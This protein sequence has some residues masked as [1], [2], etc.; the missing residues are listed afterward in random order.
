VM[1]DGKRLPGH[2]NPTAEPG[3]IVVMP[4]VAVKWW[5]DYVTII[6]A[7]GTATALIVSLASLTR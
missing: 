6:G 1:R 7:A 5:Q 2:A 4:R 3:D